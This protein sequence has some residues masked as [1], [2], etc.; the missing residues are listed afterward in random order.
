[1]SSTSNTTK[2]IA[3]KLS[4]KARE[5]VYDGIVAK[6]L[7]ENRV[8][9]EERTTSGYVSAYLGWVA[10]KKL[11]LFFLM[12]IGFAGYAVVECARSIKE[13]TPQYQRVKT[14]AK[15]IGWSGDEDLVEGLLDMGLSEDDV[16]EYAKEYTKY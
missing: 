6:C 9:P 12:L 1:M 4:E 16:R 13:S 3:R 10:F 2:D 8:E 11:L 15:E 14:L 5:I 7:Y